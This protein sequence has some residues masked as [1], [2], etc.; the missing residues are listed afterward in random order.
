[1]YLFHTEILSPVLMQI[2][3]II[4]DDTTAIIYMHNVHDLKKLEV[5]TIT[6]LFLH[7]NLN[8]CNKYFSALH[9]L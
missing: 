8:A 6:A 5:S 1:M 3:A 4:V 9:T 2:C 7:R